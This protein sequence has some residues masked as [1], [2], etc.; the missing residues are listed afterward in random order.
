MD[1]HQTDAGVIVVLVC[2]SVVAIKLA[3]PLLP[4]LLV[5]LVRYRKAVTK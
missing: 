1:M 5:A 3:P 2:A 4:V